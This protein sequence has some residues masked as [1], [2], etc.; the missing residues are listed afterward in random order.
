MYRDVPVI[1]TY[2][3]AEQYYNKTARYSKG[4]N[5]GLVPV[6]N[7]N[8]GWVNMRKGDD[9]YQIGFW[10][11][12]NSFGE[13]KRTI[14]YYK[15]NPNQ[16]VLN[17]PHYS[18]SDLYVVS[19]I[20]GGRLM[21]YQ[22]NLWWVMDWRTSNGTINDPNVPRKKYLGLGAHVFENGVPVRGKTTMTKTYLKRKEFNA[23]Y[24]KCK[25]FV[26]YLTLTNKMRDEGFSPEEVDTLPAMNLRLFDPIKLAESTNM[27]DHYLLARIIASSTNHA[28]NRKHIYW[29]SKSWKGD[30]LTLAMLEMMKHM[31]KISHAND[32]FYQKE[33]EVTGFTRDSNKQYITYLK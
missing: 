2:E 13:D 30:D 21:Q 12:L 16:A 5:I 22:F 17:I 1:Q 23:L 15:D 10:Y 9:C 31:I 11:G 19:K 3:Q 7:R 18:I 29:Q 32:V 27:D 25:P 4:R 33:V 8:R 28:V 24:K 14:T 20:L 6:G 26:D